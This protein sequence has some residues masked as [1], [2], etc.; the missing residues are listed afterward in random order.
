MFRALVLSAYLSMAV[1]AVAQTAPDV[2]VP[3]LVDKFLAAEKAYDSAA[4]AKL[5]DA[6]FVEI[7]PAGEVDEHDRFLGFYTADK[8]QEWPPM[9]VTE[10]HVRVFGDTAI[11]MVKVSYAMSGP[12]GKPHQLEIRSVFTAQRKGTEWKLIGAQHTGI[13]P[14]PTA[15]TK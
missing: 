2:A 12:D 1:S 5:I 15:A 10:K 6:K 4:L 13:R 8:K 9:T 11:E 14:V 3:A 7:S